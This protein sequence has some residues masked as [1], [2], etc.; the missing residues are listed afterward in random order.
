[1]SFGS[2]PKAP[3]V[4][5]PFDV[6]SQQQTYNTQ[7][8]LESQSGSMVNQNN[9]YGSL[10]YQQTGTDQYGNPQYSSSV[11]LNPEQQSLFNQL[12]QTK[13]AAS[14]GATNVL[15]GAYTGQPNLTTST[16]SIV[17]QNLQHQLGYLTPYFSQQSNNLDNQLRN[18][19]LMPGTPAYDNAMN[20]MRQSQGQQ[21]DSYLA[22]AQPQAFNQ[23]VQAY[24]LP[25]QQASILAALGAPGSVNSDLVNAPGLN[26]LQGPSRMPSLPTCPDTMRRRSS[27]VQVWAA[28]PVS[29]QPH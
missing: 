7:S 20:N 14:Q 22:N 5:N 10:T 19:G 26:I 25:A 15:S 28:W 16:D 2:S 21:V 9:P 29:G 13:N 3:T 12:N 24:Q 6:A 1:M 18:Q 27:R 8:G 23:A 17:N 4:Y 11:A